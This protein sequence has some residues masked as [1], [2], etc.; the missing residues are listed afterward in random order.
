MDELVNREKQPGA[1][2]ILEDPSFPHCYPQDVGIPGKTVK[3]V[4]E[5]LRPSAPIHGLLGP[6][7]VFTGKTDDQAGGS[8]DFPIP[9]DAATGFHLITV[10][11]DDTA[12]TA[13]CVVEV[14]KRR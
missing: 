8:I 13:D 4:L 1:N 7:L 12:L 11:V 2:F 10:G 14:R 5:K 3:V 6:D 9:K